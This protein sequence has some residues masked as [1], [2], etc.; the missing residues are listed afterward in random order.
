MITKKSFMMPLLMLC[1]LI[2]GI[3]YGAVPVSANSRTGQASTEAKNTSQGIGGSEN[4]DISVDANGNLTGTTVDG[5]KGG[6]IDTGNKILKTLTMILTLFMAGAAIVLAIIFICHSVN[7][8]KNA[9]NPNG[10]SSAVSGLIWTIIAA[11]LCGGVAVF[12]GL[13]FNLFRK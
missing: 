10:K 12:M 6:T 7:L 1:M 4:V 2:C 5:S 11:A 9:T 3:M 13:F 8:G